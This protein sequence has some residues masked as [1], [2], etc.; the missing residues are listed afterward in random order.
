ME[1]RGGGRDLLRGNS[2]TMRV[3]SIAHLLTKKGGG[4]KST[5][6]QRGN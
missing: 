4:R 5:K 6:L 3:G 2:E 1:S